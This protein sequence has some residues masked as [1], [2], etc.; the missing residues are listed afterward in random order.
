MRW[1]ALAAATTVPGGASAP[2]RQVRERTRFWERHARRG[3]RAGVLEGTEQ[4]AE[5]LPA[6]QAAGTA[7]LGKGVGEVGSQERIGEL[8]GDDCLRHDATA[9]GSLDGLCLDDLL[10]GGFSSPA[11]II[12]RRSA[13]AASET[14]ASHQ[15][16]TTAMACLRACGRKDCRDAVEALEL[17][18]TRRLGEL[19][20]GLDRGPLLT[21]EQSDHLELRPSGRLDLA[22]LNR[23]L[24]IADRHRE[25]RDD[26]LIGAGTG[27][28]ARA[29]ARR[30][31]GWRSR[32][33]ATDPPREHTARSPCGQL[34]PNL[35]AQSA[36]AARVAAS[37][38]ATMSR[39]PGEQVR[40]DAPTSRPDGTN[41][42]ASR[43]SR[44]PHSTSPLVFGSP[45]VP[46]ETAMRP[47]ARV[48]W[49]SVPQI[50]GVGGFDGW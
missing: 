23:R 38:D 40:V 36:Q 48:S 3:A 39:E 5:E 37:A 1:P 31:L 21:N 19:L 41:D 45:S 20:V 18:I 17:G 2:G 35:V 25:L 22:A 16:G 8:T 33:R 7:L 12:S 15:T 42:S 6:V 13:F 29:G 44:Q 49:P 30:A 27:S 4:G 26:V 11:S 14:D 28:P 34:P 47:A 46:P 24:D 10:D 50:V 9:D 32:P 43:A